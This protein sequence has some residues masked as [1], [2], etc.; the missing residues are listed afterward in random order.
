MPRTL[1]SLTLS[2]LGLAFLGRLAFELKGLFP[3][4]S[5]V[6]SDIGAPVLAFTTLV[7]GGATWWVFFRR[8]G[9]RFLACLGS[10]GMG[11]LLFLVAVIPIREEQIRAEERL[12]NALAENRTALSRLVA[13]QR[14]AERQRLLKERETQG[15]DVF[16]SYEGRV[17]L[18]ELS[19]LRQLHNQLLAEVEAAGSA[20]ELAMEAAG[21]GGLAEWLRAPSVE[22]LNTQA[23]RLAELYSAAR[24]FTELLES[25]SAAYLE[26]IDALDLSEAGR[27]A[28]LAE[29]QRLQL[30]LQSDQV[31]EFRQLDQQLVA[32]S[33]RLVRLLADDWGN[34]TWNQREQSVVFADPSLERTV[35][36][37]IAEL[38]F[39]RESADDLQP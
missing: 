31:L 7:A 21:G 11:C 14:L 20:Y 37:I 15:T 10:L 19:Q 29:R 23:S 22:Y 3:Q 1:F 39:L 24:Q 25:F 4:S 13:G 9:D 32:L 26:G 16:S 8:S 6:D 30:A 18:A 28:A 12:D 5:L 2:F 35:A 27:R 36:E 34:W 17:P 33:L 38:D